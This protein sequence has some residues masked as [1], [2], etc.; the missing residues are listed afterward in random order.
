MSRV[1]SRQWPGNPDALS[2]RGQ[3]PCDYAAYVPDQLTGRIIRLDGDVAADVADAE[4]AISR[5]NTAAVVLA[6]TEALT[7][8]LLRAESVASSRIEGL[9]VGARKLLRTEA[10]QTIGVRS[11]DITANE[12]L[13]TLRH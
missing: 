11:M 9:E 1:T 10:A 5:L 7:R 13:G 6:D 3:M 4:A 2:R 12:V 8:L